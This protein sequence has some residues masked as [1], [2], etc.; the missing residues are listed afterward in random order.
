VSQRLAAALAVI[1][2]LGSPLAFAQD[3]GRRSRS[4]EHAGREEAFKMVDAYIVSNL[5]ESLALTNEQFVDV[6][7]LVRKLQADRR[8]F[9][10]SR[11]RAL[12]RLGSGSPPER[13]SS[14][15]RTRSR[16]SRR[17]NR[18]ESAAASRRSTR[19][20]RPCSRRSTECWRWTWSSTC[21]S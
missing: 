12:R 18:R 10:L 15:S 20:S 13:R 19:R 3:A 4:A 5:Q 16:R 1:L 21:A 14:R 9:Y 17:R 6:L 7:P 11:A 8:E 2:G